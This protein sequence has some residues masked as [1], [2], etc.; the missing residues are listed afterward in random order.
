V[1]RKARRS[2]LIK[3][4]ERDKAL[5]IELMSY[6]R[7]PSIR[8]LVLLPALY[9]AGCATSVQDSSPSPALHHS[10]SPSPV[11]LPGGDGGLQK[12]AELWLGRSKE[13]AN[14]D[15]PV[16]PGL[17]LASVVIA[18][19]GHMFPADTTAVK[20]IRPDRGGSK[21]VLV[22]DL[23][24]IKQGDAS[25]IPLQSGDIIDVG[26]HNSRLIPYGLYRFF[27]TMVNIGAGGTIP[28]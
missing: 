28:S 14:S 7:A 25:D 1:N 6:I 20:V 10:I 23:V 8:A 19:G 2:C 26:A 27:S 17:T 16:M 21:T 4:K 18:A 13:K 22:V 3:E 11:S 5:E 15:F 24:K 9:L 12:L